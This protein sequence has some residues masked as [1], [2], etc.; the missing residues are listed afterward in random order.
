MKTSK[1]L[2]AFCF[3]VLLLIPALLSI[4]QGFRDVPGIVGAVKS[5]TLT[6]KEK[7]CLRESLYFEVRN[8]GLEGIEAVATV[9]LHRRDA[10]GYPGDVCS[11]VH[12][13]KQFSYRN[14]LPAGA[15]KNIQPKK[16]L[17]KQALDVIDFV[18]DQIAAG[19]F[20]RVLPEGVL[21]YTTK[22]VKNKWTKKL[23]VHAV[24]GEH[25]F[26]SKV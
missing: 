12:Q 23:K 16:A 15:S 1:I 9:I 20:V 10:K 25:V 6:E 5:S 13:P 22:S 2:Q 4:P 24:I 11:V 18:V 17:D 19:Q 7:L 3:S 26:Y 8:Q 14:D 21:W